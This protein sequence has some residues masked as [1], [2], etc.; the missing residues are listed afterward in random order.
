MEG[1][2]VAITTVGNAQGNAIRRFRALSERQGKTVD[3][4]LEMI[5]SGR[6]AFISH[7]ARRDALHLTKD[8]LEQLR[9]HEEIVV[10]LATVAAE[11]AARV[12]PKG[13]KRAG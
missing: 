3:T 11:A 12:I 6:M 9:I 1:L 7:E 2:L 8:M 5:A 13:G 4:F 10:D